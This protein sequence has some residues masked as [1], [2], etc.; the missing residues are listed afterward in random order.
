M[1]IVVICHRWHL[2]LIGDQFLVAFYF[3]ICGVLCCLIFISNQGKK[4]S[5]Y[6][7]LSFIQP[8]LLYSSAAQSRNSF[9]LGQPRTAKAQRRSWGWGLFL[10]PSLLS[11]WKPPSEMLSSYLWSKEFQLCSRKVRFCLLWKNPFLTF[12]WK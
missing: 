9:H 3:I 5:W 1:S 4:S 2:F 6:H 7:M 8:F 10:V 12:Y 11:N